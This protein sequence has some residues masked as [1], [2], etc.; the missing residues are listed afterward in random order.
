MDQDLVLTRCR[1]RCERTEQTK[2]IY[3]L[4]GWSRVIANDGNPDISTTTTTTTTT[5]MLA[6]LKITSGTVIEIETTGYEG[7]KRF[8]SW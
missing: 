8:G 2:T 7:I 3:R 1:T 5:T 6:K 4:D